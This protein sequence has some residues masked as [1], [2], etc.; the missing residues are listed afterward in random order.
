MLQNAT[1]SGNHCPNLLTSLTNMCFAL[2]LPRERH[3]CR[4]SSHVPGMP[5]FLEMLQNCKNPY[6][7]LTF[8]KVP[9][10]LRLPRKTT[11]ERPKVVRDPQ[12]LTP[13][14]SK[15]AS[16]HN[17]VHFFN[18]S[19][20]KSA[21]NLVCFARFDFEIQNW[22]EHEVLCTCWLGH[23]LRATSACNF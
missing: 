14:T 13:L 23:V 21:P 7:L 18:I 15:C 10:P 5:S 20:S 12:F 16:R 11:S 22:S 1:V 17:G 6:V 8:D 2:C 4:P 3:L 9:N 19:V